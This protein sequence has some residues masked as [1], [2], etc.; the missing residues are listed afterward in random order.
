MPPN[1]PCRKDIY[2]IGYTFRTGQNLALGT[3]SWEDAIMEWFNQINSD[4]PLVYEFR[5]FEQV[6]FLSRLS[7][8][9]INVTTNSFQ[10]HHYQKI[11][12]KIQ[13]LFRLCETMCL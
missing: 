9:L 11:L 7:I 3:D 6:R 10:Q 2:F 5:K 13:K 8:L 4:D 12:C 1:S